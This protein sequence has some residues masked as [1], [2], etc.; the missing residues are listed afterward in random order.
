MGIEK[1]RDHPTHTLYFKD[2]KQK[3]VFLFRESH[4]DAIHVSP[5]IS[6][7]TTNVNPIVRH[8]VGCPAVG[9]QAA[10]V[11]LPSLQQPGV[12]QGVAQAAA[13]GGGGMATAPP[14]TAQ[15]NWFEATTMDW[16]YK[17]PTGNIQGPFSSSEMGEWFEAGYFKKDLLIRRSCDQEFLTLGQVE[18]RYGGV[19][20]FRSARPPPAFMPPP[21]AQPSISRPPGM[22]PPEPVAQV[23]QQQPPPQQHQAQVQQPA[24]TS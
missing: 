17:D 24:V 1:Q 16:H 22:G 5:T 23:V 12:A 14:G 19:N 6:P 18:S 2:R 4:H 3:D 15:A 20:P 10:P 11:S 7:S 13:A 21:P 9:Q 8:S